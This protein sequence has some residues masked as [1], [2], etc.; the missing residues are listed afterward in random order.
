M[1]SV[2]ELQRE[3]RRRLAE[4]GVETAALDARLIVQHE[5]GISHEA[6]IADPGLP[7]D[8]AGCDAIDAS[9]AR[10]LEH[11]PVSRIIGE[12]EF[13]GRT[14]KVT[15]DVLD[16]RPDTETLIEHVLE[17]ARLK[18]APGEQLRIADIGTGS[19]AI[20]T[21][22]LAELESACG[23]AVDVSRAALD[24]ARSNALAI[25]VVDRLEF[26]ETSWL[27]GLSGP[28]DVIVSNPPYIE[29]NTISSLPPE[30]AR[31]DPV[32]ALDGGVDGLMAYRAIIPQAFERLEPGGYLCLEIG[33][34]QAKIVLDLLA[35]C[36]FADGGPVPALRQDLAG[37]DRVVTGQKP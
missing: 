9:L 18:A 10:R 25:G 1:A 34:G 32:L 8:Q 12:R 30:V 27:D 14:F 4:A 36:G 2:G 22:L 26:V 21:T 33:A 23:T 37:H 16:P 24:V 28:Y 5:L 7:V 6:L 11:E 17:I 19:G 29:A 13:F 15:P 20:I 31:F 3:A 35:E